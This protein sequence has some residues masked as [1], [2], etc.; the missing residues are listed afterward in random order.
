[1]RGGEWGRALGQPGAPRGLRTLTWGRTSSAGGWA[2]VAGRFSC[3][4]DGQQKKPKSQ[5]QGPTENVGRCGQETACVCARETHRALCDR[6]RPKQNHS[7][8]S[9]R[10]RVGAA[11]PRP[12]QGACQRQTDPWRETNRRLGRRDV[13]RRLPWG[14]GEEG[15]GDW[16]GLGGPWV[17]ATCLDLGG[18][19][20]QRAYTAAPLQWG[21]RG[22]GQ[23][24]LRGP[25]A[26]WPRRARP[27]CERA[28]PSRP[29]AQ[30]GPGRR[31]ARCRSPGS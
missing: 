15:H 3:F 22:Q 18:G 14:G 26:P 23:A 8:R 31:R 17:A 7:E 30:P 24:G 29:A 11:Q 21:K 5:S 9:G 10:F 6:F 27:G 2:A 4:W 28:A 1:M 19:L 13:R 25:G 12:R 16:G 20:T